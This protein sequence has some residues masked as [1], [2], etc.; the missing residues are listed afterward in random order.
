MVL[1]N[2]IITPNLIL[3]KARLDDLEDIYKEGL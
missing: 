3:R 1:Y 2:E